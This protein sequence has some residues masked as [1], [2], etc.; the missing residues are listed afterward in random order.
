MN[1]NGGQK[2]VCSEVAKGGYGRKAVVVR[3]NSLDSPWGE[4]DIREV[5]KLTL[6]AV[7][8]P[9]VRKRTGTSIRTGGRGVFCSV[10]VVSM[11]SSRATSSSSSSCCF[12]FSSFGQFPN[13]HGTAACFRVGGAWEGCF[14]K[15]LHRCGG[16]EWLWRRTCPPRGAGEREGGRENAAGASWP[17]P[18]LAEIELD[19]EFTNA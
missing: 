9:K 12:S 5:A 13:L 7:V 10:G 19:K 6:D 11:F 4:D 8:I 16:G 14:E 15:L 18:I 2:K 1:N 3:I 17:T